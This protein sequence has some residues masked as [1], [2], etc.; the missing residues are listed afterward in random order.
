MRGKERKGRRA[1]ET[2]AR[3]GEGK[4]R[5]EGK[6]SVQLDMNLMASERCMAPAPPFNQHTSDISFF[7]S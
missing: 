5:G 4:S 6:K 1:E 3:T 7:A 2:R